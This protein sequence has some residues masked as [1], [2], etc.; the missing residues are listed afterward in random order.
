MNRKEIRLKTLWGSVL[1]L[2]MVF[3]AGCVPP[4]GGNTVQGPPTKIGGTISGLE[5]GESVELAMTG[6]VDYPLPLLVPDVEVGNETLVF[7]ENGFYQFNE[8]LPGTPLTEYEIK[9]V[10][11]PT[12]KLCRLDN[13]TGIAFALP[14]INADVICGEPLVAGLLAAIP[15]TNLA[16]CINQ[17]AHESGATTMEE[18]DHISCSNEDIDDATGLSHFTNLRSLSLYRNNLTEIDLSNIP[19]L[20]SLDLSYNDLQTVDVSNLP[21]LTRLSL[22]GNEL[23]DI[24]VSANTNLTSLSLGS[25]NIASIELPPALELRTLDL[26]YND[27]TEIDLSTMPSLVTIRLHSNELTS[28][29]LSGNP[30]LEDIKLSYNNISSIDLSQYTHMSSIILGNNG[31]TEIDLSN[32]VEINQLDLGDNLLTN[33]ENIPLETLQREPPEELSPILEEYLD[34]AF[35]FVDWRDTNFIN[36]RNNPW[37]DATIDFFREY[38]KVTEFDFSYSRPR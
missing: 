30:A 5:E 34:Q 32:L 24:D 8:T 31:L 36:F 15:D 6:V 37:D 27:I 2:A 3:A 10:T 11:H 7:T 23:T 20:F 14:V 35:P 17:S 33:L 19:G 9:V 16:E 18:V 29:D 22:S 13:P 25:N 38:N 21:S 1:S 12:G 4:G 28:I 26:A